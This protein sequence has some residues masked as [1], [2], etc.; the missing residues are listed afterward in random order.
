M[1]LIPLIFAL[2][3][4]MDRKKYFIARHFT[5][6]QPPDRTPLNFIPQLQL[7]NFFQTIPTQKIKVLVTQVDTYSP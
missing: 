3:V 2:C 6:I 5:H 7:N 1:K 4:S